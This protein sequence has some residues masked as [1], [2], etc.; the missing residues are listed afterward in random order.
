MRTT[1]GFG[2]NLL[3]G[4]GICLLSL[5]LLV[6]PTST[7]LADAP[8]NYLSRDVSCGNAGLCDWTNACKNSSYPC[9][10]SDNCKPNPLP[11]GAGCDTCKCA[12]PFPQASNCQ[13]IP[14]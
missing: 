7:L 1:I 6:V 9:P 13:C 8:G 14:S 2:A 5:S 10:S 12:L 4:A 11:V 3:C